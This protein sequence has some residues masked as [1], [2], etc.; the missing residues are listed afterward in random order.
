MKRVESFR[1]GTRHFRW[2]HASKIV[3]KLLPFQHLIL[4]SYALLAGWNEASSPELC[5]DIVGQVTEK[6]RPGT[7]TRTSMHDDG[8]RWMANNLMDI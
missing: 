1:L 8:E 2:P 6:Q 3:I 7:F 4:F 5:D